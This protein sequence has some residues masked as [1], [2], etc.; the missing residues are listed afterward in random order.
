[1]FQALGG[2]TRYPLPFLPSIFVGG[3]SIT[4]AAAGS[5]VSRASRT[6]SGAALIFLWL[7]LGPHLGADQALR[8]IPF[9]G[10]FRYSEKLIGPFTLCVAVLAGLGADRLSRAS[11][12][13]TTVA[14]VAA[15]ISACT[16][17]IALWAG[18]DG[19]L[20]IAVA[21]DVAH[22][23]RERLT[24]GF[25]HAAVGMGLLAGALLAASRPSVR[26]HFPALAAGIVFLQSA[27]ASPFALHSGARGMRDV[28]PLSSIP[29]AGP[30]VRIATPIE[31]VSNTVAGALDDWDRLVAVASHTGEPPYNVPSGIDQVATYTG[32]FPHRYRLVDDGL[33]RDFG[34]A[35][36][37]AWRTFGLTHVVI[38]AAADVDP[39]QR[40]IAEAALPGG[41]PVLA[42]PEWGF[43]VWQ[44]PHRPWATFV[45]RAIGASS[46]GEAY[47][48]LAKAM[49]SGDPVV[50][51]EGAIPQVLTPGT[52]LA[53]WRGPDRIRIEATSTGDGLL[54]VNDAFWP[55]WT[56]TVDGRPARI[57][58][59]DALVRAVPWPAGRHVLEMAYDPNEVRLG[60]LSSLA[61]AGLTLG[62]F[63]AALRARPSKQE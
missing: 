30:L 3:A 48:R 57:L 11:R 24:I 49:A 51:L 31:G 6:L 25:A 47:Q 17:V 63:L 53:T 37:A 21:P 9:W 15:G 36:W 26:A 16:A 38:G 44:V 12:R 28:A 22:V 61:G 41:I 43:T 13:V 27:A 20:P 56:A 2:P 23:L 29:G 34:R 8:E 46:E 54:L 59:A 5:G 35:R 60:V 7:A 42:S 39:G 58:P 4:L 52:V 33:E 14:R 62:L 19:W 10:S 45:E 55:G 32:L 40:A 1:V 18:S 50:I